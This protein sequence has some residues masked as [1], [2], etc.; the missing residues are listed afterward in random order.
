MKVV[1]VIAFLIS[2]EYGR[3][4]TQK[5]NFVVLMADDLG[6]GDIG[7]FGN[8]SIPTP[9]IDRLCFEGVKFTHH[10]ATAALCTPSRAAFLTGRYAAR[11]GLAK[12]SLR[13]E[14]CHVNR[15]TNIKCI[16]DIYLTHECL[17]NFYNRTLI[18]P[19]QLLYTWLDVLVFRKLSIHGQNCY[20]T[21]GELPHS[22]CE[23]DRIAFSLYF[24]NLYIMHI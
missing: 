6:I 11:M 15:K 1:S 10:L 19:L 7:C 9:N 14:Q 20:A 21:T 18:N 2:I 16:H 13:K 24:Y 4:E 8:K 23:F 22:N 5:T 17:C 12:V 3:A